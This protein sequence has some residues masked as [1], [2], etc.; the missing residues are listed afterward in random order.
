MA[1]AAPPAPKAADKPPPAPSFELVLREAV[2]RR[3]ANGVGVGA[4][5]AAALSVVLRVACYGAVGLRQAVGFGMACGVF[6]VAAVAVSWDGCAGSRTPPRRALATTSALA[7][8]GA[9]IGAALGACAGPEAERARVAGGAVAGLAHGVRA[10]AAGG[11]GDGRRPFR[12]ADALAKSALAALRSAPFGVL[13]ARAFPGD[14]AGGGRACFVGALAA[15]VALGLQAAWLRFIAARPLDV[16]AACDRAPDPRAGP[17]KRRGVKPDPPWFVE[18]ALAAL[19]AGDGAPPP[20]EPGPRKA[21]APAARAPGWYASAGGDPFGRAGDA[22]AWRAENERHR[23]ALS[24]AAAAAA[25]GERAALASWVAP[26]PPLALD[27]GGLVLGDAVKLRFAGKRAK[28]LALEA[29]ADGACD[30]AGWL[31]SDAG[32]DAARDRALRAC[33]L[34]LDGLSLRLELRAAAAAAPRSRGG[35]VVLD[36]ALADA[37]AAGRA[38]RVAADEKRSVLGLARLLADRGAPRWLLDLVDPAPDARAAGGRVSDCECGHCANAARLAAALVAGGAWGAAKSRDRCPAALVSLLGC[39]HALRA[40]GP[41][42][43]PGVVEPAALGRLKLAVA[44]AID[45]LCETYAADLGA[46]AFPPL[47]APT[48]QRHLD[49]ARARA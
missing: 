20:K 27:S 33:L 44:A 35:A 40:A 4:A 19:E 46:F 7:L 29:L 18:V 23:A 37:L 16:D 28:T 3:V 30:A 12:A 32:G 8:V 34:A 42:A 39:Q 2:E 41:A 22:P 45:A 5:G 9:A 17:A 6:A 11:R 25:A 13:L 48:L 31:L 36:G 14:G 49:A 26:P 1:T 47:Y 24:D 10:A 15:H 21:P 43:P 38:A